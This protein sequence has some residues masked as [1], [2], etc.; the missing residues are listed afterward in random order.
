MV[1]SKINGKIIIVKTVIISG[2]S[3]GMGLATAKKLASEGYFIYGLD[4]KEPNEKIDNSKFILTDLRDQESVKKAYEI[5]SKEVKEIEAIINMAGIYDLNSLVE[6]SEEDFMRIFDINVFATYR[7]NK[8]FLPLLKEKGKVII[9]SSELAPLDPLPFTGL[10]GITKSTIEKYAYSLRM[11]LQL[12]NKLVVV[13]RPG[14]VNTSLLDISTDRID[15]FEK[16]TKLYS[17]NASKFKKITNKVE[18]RK[19]PPIKIANLASK[20]LKKKKPKYV[21]KINRNPLLLL[22]NI[23]PQRFQNWIIKKILLS[24]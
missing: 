11:E 10:Y 21:Y 2:F 15:K 4:I 18:A 19:V 1:N 13:I 9:T 7:L 14:A 6:I 23:L 20:I 5:V 24:K 22:L 3:G 12:L 8:I 17:Y 16:N